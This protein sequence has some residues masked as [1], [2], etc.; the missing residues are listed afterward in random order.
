VIFEILLNSLV[1]VQRIYL[2]RFLFKVRHISG[3]LNVVADW[4][5]R[6][7]LLHDVTTIPGDVKTV[8]ATVHGGRAAHHGTRRTWAVEHMY[9]QCEIINK[10]IIDPLVWWSDHEGVYPYTASRT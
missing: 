7:F 3:K 8:L 6:Y 2:A 1:L 4:Q 10:D 9:R 5:S